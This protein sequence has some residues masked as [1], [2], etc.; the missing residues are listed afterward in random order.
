MPNE[1]ASATQGI[2]AYSNTDLVSNGFITEIATD[3]RGNEIRMLPSSRMTVELQYS[4]RSDISGTNLN[5]LSPGGNTGFI[6]GGLGGGAGFG[7]G[8]ALGCSLLGDIEPTRSKFIF[9]IAESQTVINRIITVTEEM[10]AEATANDGQIVY[11]FKNEYLIGVLGVTKQ[12]IELSDEET[13]NIG[14]SGGPQRGHL[15]DNSG[16]IQATFQHF[17]GDGNLFVEIIRDERKYLY[18][19]D[20]NTQEDPHT[21]ENCF[22]NASP[23]DLVDTKIRIQLLEHR[24]PNTPPPEN[25]LT[26]GQSIYVTYVAAKKR[27]LRH[28]IFASSFFFLFPGFLVERIGIDQVKAWNFHPFKFKAQKDIAKKASIND[29]IAD[30]L[31]DANENLTEEQKDHRRRL[32]VIEAQRLC[33]CVNDTKN[34][35]GYI[36]GFYFADTRGILSYD[37]AADEVTLLI[38]AASIRDQD[39]WDGL[40]SYIDFG[41]GFNEEGHLDPKEEGANRVLRGFAFDISDHV[42]SVCFDNDK[43]GYQRQ[44]AEALATVSAFDPQVEDS[45]I[46]SSNL[47]LVRLGMPHRD[48]YDLSSAKFK[49]TKMSSIEGGAY[50]IRDCNKIFTYDQQFC[51]S[52]TLQSDMF[53][54]TP[55]FFDDYP[56]KSR[57]YVERFSPQFPLSRDGGIWVTT[58]PTSSSGISVD[59]HPYQND[60]F[61]VF[62]K[63]GVLNYHRFNDAKSRIHLNKSEFDYSDITRNHDNLQFDQLSQEDVTLV[64]FDKIIGNQPGYSRGLEITRESGKIALGIESSSIYNIDEQLFVQ[65]TETG[66]VNISGLSG[67]YIKSISITY[68]PKSG[69]LD[70]SRRYISFIFPSSQTII[71]NVALPYE[72]TAFREKLL[73]LDTRYYNGDSMRMSGEILKYLTIRKVS[74]TYL[75]EDKYQENAID[76]GASSVI[77]DSQGR[78]YV[79]YEDN[80]GAEGSYEGPGDG[81]QVSEGSTSE[82]SCLIS[83]DMGHTW[84][85]HKGV[86]Y[87]SGTESIRNP[88]AVMDRKSNLIHLFYIINDTL[89]RKTISPSLFAAYDAFKAWK[90]P[91]LFNEDTPDNFGLIHFSDQGKQLRKKESNV[92]IGNTA[93]DGFLRKQLSITTDR[94]TANKFIRISMSGDF[95]NFE[96]GFPE[97]DFIAFLDRK[98]ALR[99][100]YVADGKLFAR[101]SGDNGK[102]WFDV[103]KEG[104]TFHKNNKV[105]EARPISSLGYTFDEHSNF[106]HLSYI[107]DEML[108][109]RSFDG[110]LF[111]EAGEEIKRV[112]NPS[113]ST[114]RP[115]FIVGAISDE[116]ARAIVADTTNIVYTYPISSLPLFNEK[117]SVSEVGAKGFVGAS[118]LTRFYYQDSNGELRAFSLLE[119][120]SPIL[121]AKA[122]ARR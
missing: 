16:K 105:Q 80:K 9:H 118:G 107:A 115:T 94:K 64:G 41:P 76:A 93:I 56:K 109:L 82:I 59:A 116:V 12:A 67:K 119:S 97:T 6:L 43:F 103:F 81:G 54:R 2:L 61:L 49:F 40:I 110:S 106:L 11:D 77:L 122:K 37:Q 90:R 72:G 14:S 8:A 98:R 96:Q 26:A 13:E 46:G 39:W 34:S 1:C 112:V 3:K 83:N 95:K 45:G 52:G 10:L 28:A 17:S 111:A 47:D 102:G 88:Y 32:E 63:S 84:F 5:N 21:G 108:F 15:I 73:Y 69:F 38:P 75:D 85:D 23:D 22:L 65:N 91:V 57:I 117:M 30:E 4:I 35:R 62:E 29:I 87:T 27:L 48:E 100:L 89:L 20:N 101:V 114:S 70:Q 58:R 25:P 24:A 120:R 19:A 66:E 104:V 36:R 71:D 60:G 33:E 92:V 51:A 44:L 42:N 121:D 79:F 78:I 50:F 68:M 113:E 7:I 18:R 74:I 86:V 99:L 31:T 53:I 55:I